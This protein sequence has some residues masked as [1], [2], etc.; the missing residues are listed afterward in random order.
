VP[1]ESVPECDRNT[2][3]NGGPLGDGV[4]ENDLPFGE[5]MPYLASPHSGNPS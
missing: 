3:N 1:P 4:D 2:H 5:Q